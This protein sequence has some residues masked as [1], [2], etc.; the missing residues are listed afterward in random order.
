MRSESEG[1]KEREWKGWVQGRC[2][3]STQR[4]SSKVEKDKRR[5]TVRKAEWSGRSSDEL[6]PW[7]AQGGAMMRESSCQMKMWRREKRMKEGEG[8][9]WILQDVAFSR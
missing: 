9:E 7:G 5:R 2:C 6:T 8:S 1:V 4:N 3:D